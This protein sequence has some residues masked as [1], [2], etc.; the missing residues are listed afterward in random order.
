MS[1]IYL[2]NFSEIVPRVSVK[3][4]IARG[5]YGHQDSGTHICFC[6]G[7][8]GRGFCRFLAHNSLNLGRLEKSLGVICR[9]AWP[10]ST[11]QISA[12]SPQG[13]PRN[14]RSREVFLFCLF[15]LFF[16][17]FVNVN[18][19]HNPVML[20]FRFCSQPYLQEIFVSQKN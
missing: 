15:F 20:K 4:A 17:F 9:Y 19:S 7:Q 10:L 8:K 14:S 2:A 12:K 3:F 16:C 1:P 11:L 13:S 5:F 6:R 18:R